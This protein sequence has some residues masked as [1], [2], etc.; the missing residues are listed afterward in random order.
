[1]SKTTRILIADDHTLVRKGLQLMLP[2]ELGFEVIGEAADGAGVLELAQ[3]LQPD[4]VLLDLRMPCKD[5][6]QVIAELVE[7]APSVH[8]L[9]LTAVTE[10]EELYAAI[11]DGAHGYV[12]KEWPPRAIVAAIRDVTGR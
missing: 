12:L 6:H 8:I 5:G 4:V 2:G 7:T 1:M 9:V 10:R 3:V 11:R